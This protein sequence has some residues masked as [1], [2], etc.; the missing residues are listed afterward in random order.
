MAV[1]DSSSSRLSVDYY[2]LSGTNG[3]SEVVGKNLKSFHIGL[4]SCKE[5]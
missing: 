4:L 5:V 3:N 1:E 2:L